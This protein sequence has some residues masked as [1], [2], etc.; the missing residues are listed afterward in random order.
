MFV[1][2]RA[3]TLTMHG[4]TLTITVIL[5]VHIK[6]F[7]VHWYYLIIFSEVNDL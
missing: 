1:R 3:I 4:L 5:P 7:A 2:L 6:Q